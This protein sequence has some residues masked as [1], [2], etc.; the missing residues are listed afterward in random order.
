MADTPY[1]SE[2]VWDMQLECLE[3]IFEELHQ[4][5]VAVIDAAHISQGVYLWGML[6][7]W[8]IQQRYV[9]NDF[10]DDPALTGIFVCRVLLHGQDVS[11]DDRLSKITNGVKKLE[12]HDRQVQ[13]DMK[14]LQRDVKELKTTVK[15]IKAKIN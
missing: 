3:Q 2:E 11:L 6:R 1:T 8:Q 14:Q 9:S 5:R 13:S 12:E 7:A 4:A 10:Q 15:E